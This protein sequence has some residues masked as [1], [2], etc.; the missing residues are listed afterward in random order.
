MWGVSL[1]F[2]LYELNR[3]MNDRVPNEWVGPLR[4]GAPAPDFIKRQFLSRPSLFPLS[5]KKKK[6][7]TVLANSQQ[8]PSGK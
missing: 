3:L 5:K 4:F 8:Q 1:L 7:F 6:K 2:P